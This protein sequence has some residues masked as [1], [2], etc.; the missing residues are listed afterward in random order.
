MTS[1]VHG[2]RYFTRA[3]L[4]GSTVALGSWFVLSDVRSF[5]VMLIPSSFC[6]SLVV[7]AYAFGR[8][9]SR[10]RWEAAWEAYLAADASRAAIGPYEKKQVQSILWPHLRHLR[11]ASGKTSVH[12]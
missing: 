5:E 4:I 6:L 11:Q 10:E 2:E 12:I 3:I 8:V 7:V 9:R 1:K